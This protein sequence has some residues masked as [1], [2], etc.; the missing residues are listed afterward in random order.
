[1]MTLHEELV[2]EINKTMTK[3]IDS[4]GEQRK[5][6]ARQV[7]KDYPGKIPLAVQEKILAGQIVVGMAPYECHLAAGGFAF[8]VDADPMV[9]KDKSDPYQVMWKQS[10]KPDN[11]EIWMTFET[12][13]QYPEEGCRRFQVHFMKGRAVEII[14]I[15]EGQ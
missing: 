14:K 4:L 9:W 5:Q 3:E 10:T 6:F 12:D 11:S 8:R 15:G 7:F 2:L 1:M 13:T